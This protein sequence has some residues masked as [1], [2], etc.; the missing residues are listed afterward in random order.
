[1]YRPAWG[2]PYPNSFRSAI[3]AGI[4]HLQISSLPE[5]SPRHSAS[6]L[7]TTR[8]L[9]TLEPGLKPDQPTAVT[10]KAVRQKSESRL[11]IRDAPLAGTQADASPKPT[12]WSRLPGA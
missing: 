3:Y 6:S 4:G 7:R 12:A 2:R 10:A 8:Q 1:M 9:P 5:E 11:Q